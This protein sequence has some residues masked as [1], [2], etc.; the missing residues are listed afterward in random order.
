MFKNQI[1]SEE[2]AESQSDEKEDEK[3]GGDDATAFE[4]PFNGDQH[5]DYNNNMNNN[6]NNKMG[7]PRPSWPHEVDEIGSREGHIMM[8]TPE[9]K[10]MWTR[11]SG[12]P[13]SRW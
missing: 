6:N 13:R 2:A 3:G 11:S 9:D 12:P 5:F 8:G 1:K 10:R 7:P 4:R